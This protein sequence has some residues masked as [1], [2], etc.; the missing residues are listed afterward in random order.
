MIFKDSHSNFSILQ[1]NTQCLRNK[2]LQLEANQFNHNILCFSEHWLTDNEIKQLKIPNYTI[3]SHFSRQ[4]HGHGGVAVAAIDCLADRFF[5]RDDLKSLSVEMNCEICA[6]QSETLKVIVITVYRPPSGNYEI[7]FDIMQHT[8]DQVTKLNYS[9]FINGD[10]NINFAN[11]NSFTLGLTDL[12]HSYGLKILIKSNTRGNACLDNVFTNVY[13]CEG[14]V[15]DVGFSD[16]LAVIAVCDLPEPSE[17]PTV[18][19]KCRPVTQRGLL[20]FRDLVCDICWDFIADNGINTDDKFKMFVYF[21]KNCADLAFPEKTFRHKKYKPMVSWF[22]EQL[23]LKRETLNFYRELNRLYNTN[24]T[25]LLLKNYTKLY[26]LELKK[27]KKEA[28]DNYLQ[29]HNHSPK[30]IWDLIKSSTNIGNKK[31]AVSSK[32]GPD[33]V[34]QFFVDIP[35]KLVEALP[36]CNTSSKDYIDQFT[37]SYASDLKFTMVE[38][39]FIEVRDL[40]KDLKNKNSRDYY[41][42]N[43][44]IIKSVINEIV[45]PL[46]KLINLC[47]KDSLY[48]SV[49]KIARVIPIYKKGPI[50]QI[51]NYRPISIVPIFSKVFEMALKK[52]ISTYFE[53]NRLFSSSQFGFRS[54]RSTTMAI[55]K[56]I[57]IVNGGYENGDY[58]GALFCDLS[59]AFDCVSFNLLIGK[60]R[61]YKFDINSVNLIMSYLSN[62]KQLVDINGNTSN[63]ENV[64]YGVPQGSVLGP[65]L[66]LIYI[67]DL[68]GCVPDAGLVLFADDT[69]VLKKAKTSTDIITDMRETQSKV[70]NWFTS[71]QLNLNQ[72]KTEVLYFSLRSLQDM[73]FSTSVRFLGVKIDPKL[74]WNLH[75]DEVCCKVASGVFALRS[76]VRVVSERVVLSVY[77]ACVESKITYALLA[78]GHAPN[79]KRIFGLQRRAI[80]V[81]RN[82][83]YRADCKQTFIYF[84]ILTVPCLYILQCLVHMKENSHN[85]TTHEN[86]HDHLTRNRSHICTDYHRIDKIKTG[87]SFY[88]PKMFNLLPPSVKLLSKKKFTATIKQYLTQKCFYSIDE[89]NNNDFSDLV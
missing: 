13:E 80:R 75:I 8:L 23:R 19:T 28:N 88:A 64:L 36:S 66:F 51:S 48:P 47:I 38:V 57:E 89:F 78:W 72:S 68:E 84:N 71:N 45:Y 54:S 22:N 77:Y 25:N 65:L 44:K 60:L 15:Q 87:I 20:H 27:A 30:A 2:L 9:L 33:Q 49:L 40:L 12:I 46:T 67:N 61:N 62:R 6:I 29:D 14:Y 53:T 32:L 10:F 42:L 5:P 21:L 55:N 43:S 86:M 39:T 18:T 59:K 82:L 79:I 4:F 3:I 83:H 7:F 26:R 63:L 16:H 56:L 70:T 74:T 11:V 52:Q 50:D 17:E 1:I 35:R 76:L 85:Y 24:Q 81:M 41:G 31:S 34:N 69:N 73:E 37:T 58:L